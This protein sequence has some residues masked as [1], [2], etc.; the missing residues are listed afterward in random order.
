MID[1]EA[2]NQMHPDDLRR[3]H[4]VWIELDSDIPP[5]GSFLQLLPATI[6]GYGFHDKKWGK[7]MGSICSCI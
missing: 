1:F 4:E 5:D 6:R 2:Y 7:S 3:D